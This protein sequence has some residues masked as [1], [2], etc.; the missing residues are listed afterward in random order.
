MLVSLIEKIADPKLKAF[1]FRTYNV[2]K[3]VI[4]PV[5]IGMLLEDLKENP[6]ELNGLLDLHLWEE[7]G[8]AVIITL[9][10][11]GLAGLDKLTRVG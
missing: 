9:L 4:L 11:S 5:V 8:Y 2:F 7:I 10:G 6:G 1:V 3:V